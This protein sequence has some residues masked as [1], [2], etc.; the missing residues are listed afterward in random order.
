MSFE[1]A[2]A[3]A[4][5]PLHHSVGE[6]LRTEVPTFG[7]HNTLDEIVRGLRGRKFET[8]ALIAICEDRKLLGILRMEDVLAAPGD[9]RARDIM[10][11]EP[12][13]AY[14]G[15]D[16]E[17]AAW[18]AIQRGDSAV[19]VINDNGDFL[20]LVPPSALVSVLL[21]EHDEDMARLGGFM[22]DVSAV[23]KVSRESVARRYW[24]RLP[25]LLVGLAGA[26]FAAVIVGFFEETLRS[27][28]LLA[29]FLPGIVYMADAVGTQ[30]ETLII[31]GLSVGVSVG[32]VAVREM[33]TGVLVGLTISIGFLPIALIFWGDLAVAKS[34]ALALFAATSTATLVAMALPW[35]LSR[36]G[37]DPAF[38]SGPLATVVQDLLSIAIY[39]LVASTLIR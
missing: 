31:R 5:E 18:R 8:T 36:F 1:S 28:V 3:S 38:G 4:P 25:W 24:H 7:P 39:F 2:P 35:M 23:Q 6:H 30:T 9:L 29:L 26:G 17:V 22:H 19:P 20:G 14:A 12:P 27:N 34:V 37:R 16:Q 13:T 11:V 15:D 33:V 10:D 32:Q 21:Q